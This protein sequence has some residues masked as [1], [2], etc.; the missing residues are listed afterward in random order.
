MRSDG[1]HRRSSR[2]R[3]Q[4]PN[5]GSARAVMSDGASR[6]NRRNSS[7]RSEETSR[8]PNVTVSV[9]GTAYVILKWTVGLWA[10]RRARAFLTTRRP[11]SGQ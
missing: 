9:W 10:Y 5:C 2:A 11:P 8:G 4:S 1:T 6:S 7:C 3:S